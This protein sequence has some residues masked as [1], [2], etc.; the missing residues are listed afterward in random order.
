MKDS[1][2]SVKDFE[3]AESNLEIT[4]KLDEIQLI[5]VSELCNQY[6]NKL[7]RGVLLNSVF[8]AFLF[9]LT[10]LLISVI[11]KIEYL[12]NSKELALKKI[13]GYSILQRNSVTIAINIF[14]V[15][16]TALSV[17]AFTSSPLSAA[18]TSSSVGFV[19]GC[20]GV[21]TVQQ[22]SY[23]RMDVSKVSILRE[24]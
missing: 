19:F 1:N 10:V 18:L 7:I 17:R 23:G 4:E 22:S 16:R 12:V 8:S 13:F 2:N 14:S 15:L 5:N 3:L 9:V 11:T 24:I 21:N 6:R 20:F